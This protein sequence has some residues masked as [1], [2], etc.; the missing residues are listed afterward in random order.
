MQLVNRHIT[1]SRPIIIQIILPLWVHYLIDKWWDYSTPPIYTQRPKSHIRM[2][3]RGGAGHGIDCCVCIG[4]LRLI[5]MCIYLQV[6]T[7]TGY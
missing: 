2:V 7:Q 1:P 5:K 4:L 6:T 3:Q